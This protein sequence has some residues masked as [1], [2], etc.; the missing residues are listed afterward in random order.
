MEAKS[1]IG[2][3]FGCL[4]NNKDPNFTFF[5]LPKDIER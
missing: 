3:V 5:T 2:I 1:G 4:N